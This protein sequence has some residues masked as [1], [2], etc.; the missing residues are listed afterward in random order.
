MPLLYLLAMPFVLLY[1]IIG[2]IFGRRMITTI[3]MVATG[4]AGTYFITAILFIAAG[5]A[6]N[7]SVQLTIGFIMIAALAIGVRTLVSFCEKLA[8]PIMAVFGWA[9]NPVGLHLT[10]IDLRIQVLLTDIGMAF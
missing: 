7:R 1:G 3:A 10:Q 2:R 6:Y 9:L 5:V 8:G 4:L